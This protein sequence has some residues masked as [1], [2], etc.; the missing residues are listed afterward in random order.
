M[1]P[2]KYKIFLLG[3]P[4]HSIS[5][6]FLIRHPRMSMRKRAKLF[7][8]FAALKGYEDLLSEKNRIYERKRD[9]TE[10][11]CD[12]LN[13]ALLHI[14]KGSIIKVEYFV[15]PDSKTIEGTYEKIVGVVQS[16]DVI[17][18]SM[19]LDGTTIHFDDLFQITFDPSFI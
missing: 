17:K 16:L 13:E 11:E 4:A 6:P 18:Q 3:R 9:L 12:H 14:R 10:E 8:P 7:K 5:D 1:Q 15:A 19:V 2:D